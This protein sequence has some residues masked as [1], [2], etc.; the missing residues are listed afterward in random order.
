MTTLNH[1]FSR[2]KIEKEFA[3]LI[4]IILIVAGLPI[5]K[6]VIVLILEK[7]Y[8]LFIQHAMGK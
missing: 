8:Q 4:T 7:L 5:L 3:W 2:S 6:N 1:N